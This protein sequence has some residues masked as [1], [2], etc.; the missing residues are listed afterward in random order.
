MRL[1]AKTPN[2]LKSLRIDSTLI[3]SYFLKKK[4]GYYR[5]IPAFMG[6]LRQFKEKSGL[7]LLSDRTVTTAGI[8]SPEVF[9]QLFENG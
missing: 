7:K 3:I 4:R 6:I 1:V 5:H 8:I 9:D 2:R